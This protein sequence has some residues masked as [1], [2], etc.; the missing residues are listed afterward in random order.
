MYASESKRVCSLDMLSNGID[1][2]R[3]YTEYAK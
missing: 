1:Y 3:K 2:A